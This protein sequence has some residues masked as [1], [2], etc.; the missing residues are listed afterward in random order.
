MANLL[1][2]RYLVS[3]DLDHYFFLAEYKAAYPDALIIGPDGLQ[4]KLDKQGKG[5]KL[6]GTYYKDAEGTTYGFEHEVSRIFEEWT[7]GRD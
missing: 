5:T 4:A 7:V 1:S 6:D 2:T 3:A